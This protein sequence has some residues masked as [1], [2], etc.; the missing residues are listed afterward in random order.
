MAARLLLHIGTQKSGTTYLQR[1]LQSLA[2]QL[3]ET[4]VLY[5]TRIGGKTEV[6]NHEAAAYG[7]LGRDSFP[8]VPE[9]R[10]AAQEAV[11]ARLVEQVNGWS[12]T[13]IISGEALS[14]ISASAASTLVGALNVPETHVIITARDL[15][16]VLPS[17]WQQHIRNGRGTAFG[18]YLRQ[19]AQRR[20]TGNAAQRAEN[21]EGDPDQTFWR[22][23]AIGSLVSRWAPLARSVTVVTVPR[24]SDN[25]HEL[26]QRFVQALDL[27]E[28]LPQIPPAI[29]KLSANIGI[30]EP[31]ALV[32]AGLNRQAALT[33]TDEPVLR[34]MRAHIVRAGFAPRSERGNPVRLPADWIDTVRTWAGED[35][36]ELQET[37]ARIVGPVD[38][39]LVGD[40]TNY[41]SGPDAQQVAAAAGAALLAMDQHTDD[42]TTSPDEASPNRRGRRRNTQRSS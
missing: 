10:A 5:P 25:P 28:S 6:Y 4:G 21:W 17:S 2:P 14:V 29:D 32:L 11:W 7:L 34:S 22:A 27:T 33:D 9:H 1:V 42:P 38:D 23:Y 36:A 40:E 16:R 18:A 15:G 12:G 35:V 37:T 30:T 20:G 41:T 39:L 19:L 13:A 26:W 24:K 8:W 31:E 3:R